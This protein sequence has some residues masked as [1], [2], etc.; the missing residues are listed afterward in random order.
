MARD[1]VYT[2]DG[3]YYEDEDLYKAAKKEAEGVR[4]MKSRIDM[5]QPEQVLDIYRRMITQDTFQT[6]V[7]Y[8]Y[9]RELQDYLYTMPQIRNEQIPAIP[10]RREVKVLDA[11]GTTK[12]LR[13]ENKK[14]SRAFQISFAV[15]VLALVVII[16]MFA[17]AMSSSSPTV[18]NYENELL[19]KYSAWE[20]ELNER[21][22]AVK[23]K[24]RAL[25]DGD[26]Y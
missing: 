5:Q 16:A 1:S 17:I 22:A 7:G 2:V 4:Y 9:L 24:E 3:F 21:E 23:E 25:L 18:L 19:D 15:N 10:V 12:R 11:A 6:Q 8:A 20:E 14:S 13:S 26:S